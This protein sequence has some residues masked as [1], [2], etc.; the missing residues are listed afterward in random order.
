MAHALPF[1]F[2]D[3]TPRFIIN[4][5][6]TKLISNP[7]EFFSDFQKEKE[8]VSKQADLC[9]QAFH[10]SPWDGAMKFWSLITR[11]ETTTA[12]KTGIMANLFI[13]AGV[14]TNSPVIITL[15]L[16]GSTAAHIVGVEEAKQK[17]MMDRM[18]KEIQKA[19]ISLSKTNKALLRS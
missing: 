10:S 17:E 16:L 8:R 13:A 18:L 4:L 7:D 9:I 5:D 14:I 12:S 3:L 15:S 11:N 1:G 2:Q 6:P 19:N